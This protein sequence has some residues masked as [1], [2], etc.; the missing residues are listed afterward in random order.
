MQVP[1]SVLL[2]S[3]QRPEFG[4]LPWS[5]WSHPSGVRATHVEPG[6]EDRVQLGGL[7]H[8]GQ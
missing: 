5:E 4:P 1:C 2:R 7:G 6:T 8:L 3:G